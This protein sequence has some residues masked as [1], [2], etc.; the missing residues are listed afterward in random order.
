MEKD[1]GEKITSARCKLISRY[2]TATL[3][4]FSGNF[5]IIRHTLNKLSD[6]V[7]LFN[8][9]A[10]KLL[11]NIYFCCRILEASKHLLCI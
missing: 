4:E 9:Y 11:K 3:I 2:F 7:Y 5:L 1:G 6:N 10:L 8:F